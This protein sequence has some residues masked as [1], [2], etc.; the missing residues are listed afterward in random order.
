M[1][2]KTCS[3]IV[4]L[5]SVFSASTS[6][7]TARDAAHMVPTGKGWGAEAMRAQN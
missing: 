4:L 1:L 3:C 2:A 6:A 5:A 7:Q